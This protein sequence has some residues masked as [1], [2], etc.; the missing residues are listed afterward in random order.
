MRPVIP[1]LALGL[2][3]G[4]CATPSEYT[5]P[6]A[7]VPPAYREAAGLWKPAE[8][9]DQLDRGRWWEL[10]GDEH[11]NALARRV[12]G[13]NQNVL[14]AEAR[15]RQ[16]LAVTRQA[17]AGLYPE[18]TGSGAAGRSGAAGSGGKVANRFEVGV[19]ASWE[20]DLW[21]RVRR[22][23]DA[24]EA[25]AQ[26]SAA[27]LESV[28]LSAI[29]ALVQNYLSLRIVDAQARLLADSVAAFTRSLELTRNRYAVGVAGRS[30]VVLAEAQV[31]STQAQ[32][33]D[34]GVLRA[35]LEHAIAVLVGE[36][37]AALAIAAT[38]APLAVPAV[39]AALP[40]ELLERRPDIAAAERRVAAANARIGVAQAAFFPTVALSGSAGLRNSVLPELL[41]A[42]SSFWSL[43]I[44]AAQ[45]LFDAGARRA[46]TD[47]ARAAYD[48]EVASYR[49]TVLTG[50]QEVE[51]NL[52][53][54]RVLAEETKV[55]EEAV[56][57]SRTSVELTMNRYRAGAVSF[58][59]VIA[60]QTILLGNE[61]TLVTLLG[62]R[63]TATVLLVKALGG[64]WD[65]KILAGGGVNPSPPRP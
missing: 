44:A 50:F 20:A 3:A 61:R 31:K 63:L 24:G 34:L 18:V 32:L 38:N 13:A 45:V 23:I 40:S 57:A 5:R 22:T 51:D 25:Q 1:I 37:P 33:V 58:L 56:R 7:N 48:A 64:G 36:P 27:D 60:V 62:R 12:E 26:A 2:L 54:L 46:V 10:F 6:A 47:Q 14:L 43:G 53:A 8:P 19:D 39:P 4:A 17:R 11:L 59:D 9:R 41:T 28:R 35:Q 15:V 55:Q 16:A 52:A 21:G 30:D 49:Q 29:A 42:P 65:G